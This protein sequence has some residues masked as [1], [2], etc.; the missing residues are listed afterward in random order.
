MKGATPPAS[1]YEELASTVVAKSVQFIE[2]RKD[3]PF[4]L[5]IGLFERTFPAWPTAVR[6]HEGCG[7]AR[8]RRPALD[9]QSEKS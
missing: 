3:K 7:C 1:R 6:R 9:W 5:E 4:F 8:R 2:Q